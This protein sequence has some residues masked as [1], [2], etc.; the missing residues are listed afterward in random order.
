VEEEEEDEEEEVT[1]EN[2]GKNRE[3]KSHQKKRVWRKRMGKEPLENAMEEHTRR[4]DKS[5]PFF[6][7]PFS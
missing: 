3:T 4:Q 2:V 7:K 5:K 1:I 6:I